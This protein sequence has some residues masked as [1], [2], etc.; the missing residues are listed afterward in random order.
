MLLTE[1]EN[2]EKTFRQCCAFCGGN[3]WNDRCPNYVT[4]E[5]RKQFLLKLGGCFLCLKRGHRAFECFNHKTCFFCKR[6]NFHHRSLCEQNVN[7]IQ[8]NNT[9]V[10]NARTEQHSPKPD[11]ETSIIVKRV[12]GIANKEQ[13][14]EESVR[15]LNRSEGIFIPEYDQILDDRLQTNSELAESTTGNSLLK[16]I[17]SQLQSKQETMELANN[18]LTEITQQL[19]DEINSFKSKIEQMEHSYKTEHSV[20]SRDVRTEMSATATGTEMEQRK[21]NTV[22]LN[23][24][25]IAEGI[26]RN[27]VKSADNQMEQ[28]KSFFKEQTLFPECRTDTQGLFTNNEQ[29]VYAWVKVLSILTQSKSF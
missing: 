12:D 10:H 18:Q 21:Q 29:I 24:Q 9:K 11:T 28:L 8:P 5:E 7:C 14:P 13:M 3:H 6:E 16:K 23:K 19:K 17:I 26:G 20:D 4:P 27:Q 1:M 2:K 15:Q 22:S 25:S